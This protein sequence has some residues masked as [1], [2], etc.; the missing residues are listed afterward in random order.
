MYIYTCMHACM[1]VYAYTH[2]YRNACAHVHTCMSKV[3]ICCVGYR[4]EPWYLFLHNYS[5]LLIYLSIYL[6]VCPSI[7]ASIY[8][9]VYLSAH[10]C[11]QALTDVCACIIEVPGTPNPKP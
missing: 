11:R 6:A 5:Y 1:Y 2:A 4:P 10:T 9:S 3:F 8:L 7:Y